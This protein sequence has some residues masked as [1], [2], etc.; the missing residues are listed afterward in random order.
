ML[1]GGKVSC[2][3]LGPCHRAADRNDLQRIERG[4]R[5]IRRLRVERRQGLRET[6]PMGRNLGAIGESLLVLV[7]GRDLR[8]SFGRSGILVLID[9]RH[10]RF[11]RGRRHVSQHPEVHE[12]MGDRPGKHSSRSPGGRAMRLPSISHA[13]P[14]A[15]ARATPRGNTRYIWVRAKMPNSGLPKSCRTSS[16]S[17]SWSRSL[18]GSAASFRSDHL[19]LPYCACH[20][21]R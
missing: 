17:R 18:L 2:L 6:R 16:I 20:N 3:D 8:G 12:E 9:S 4:R 7:Y 21:A 10:L 19:A 15:C 5:A 13:S 1:E 11:L 14:V